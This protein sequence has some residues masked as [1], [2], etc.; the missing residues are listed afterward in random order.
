VLDA[1]S[2]EKP[3][4]L[5]VIAVGEEMLTA[6]TISAGSPARRRTLASASAA[7]CARPHIPYSARSDS[8]LARS[9]GFSVT[10][11]SKAA[12]AGPAER[13]VT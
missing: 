5:D 6:V 1:D 12:I 3:H 4:G 8:Q 7:C 10:A 2:G 11:R 13:C 9:M